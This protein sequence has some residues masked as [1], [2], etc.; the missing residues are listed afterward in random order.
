[1][2][3]LKNV[4]SIVKKAPNAKLLIIGD[5][6]DLNEYKKYCEKNKLESNVIF[7]VTEILFNVRCICNSIT[8]RNARTNRN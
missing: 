8:K 6:P 1:M 4:K 2:F 3:L 7:A 5:G